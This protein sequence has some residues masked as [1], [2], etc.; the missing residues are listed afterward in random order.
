[1][2]ETGLELPGSAQVPWHVTIASSNP[3]GLRACCAAR[4]TQE[5]SQE[6]TRG[7]SSRLVVV[8]WQWRQG[9]PAVPLCGVFWEQLRGVESAG[10]RPWLESDLL[11]CDGEQ[12]WGC[13]GVHSVARAP[14]RPARSPADSPQP[15]VCSCGWP[16]GQ[17]GCALQGSDAFSL[18]RFPRPLTC[19][20]AGTWRGRALQP[21]RSMSPGSLITSG[22]ARAMHLPSPEDRAGL[23]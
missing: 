23:R 11:R 22:K 1:M 18:G 17:V 8:Q 5:S 3:G 19:W 10:G 6:M 13:Q 15:G 7:M 4:C 12:T 16:Q 2:G 9:M 21:S 14:C 20:F